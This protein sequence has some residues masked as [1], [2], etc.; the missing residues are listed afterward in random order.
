MKVANDRVE[1]RVGDCRDLLRAMPDE[2]VDCV[3]TSP[4]YFALRDYGVE[5]QIGL[6]ETP[7]AFVEELVSVFEEV[8]RVLRS[9]GT[10]WI[11]LGDSY[12]G[13]GRGGGGSFMAE[14]GDASW[15]GKGAAT[16]WQSPPA[17]FKAKDLM[18]MPWRVAL[19]LQDAGWFLRQDII[20]HKP[21]PMP[22]SVAD[23]CTK[24]HEY[25]FLLSKARR[26]HY[27]A[28]AIREPVTP[29]TVARV[30]QPN[31]GNQ[32]GS[33]RVP[34][35]T[36]GPM[37]AV[38][39]GHEKRRGHERRHEGL[40]YVWDGLTKEE[41]AAMGRNKPS[42]WT[43]ARVTFKSDHTATYPPKL[44]EPCILAG[45]PKGGVVL[46]PFG[47]AGTTGLVAARHGR[48]AI[49]LELNPEYAAIARDRIAAEWKEPIAGEPQDFGPLFS[50]ATG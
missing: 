31:W 9:D 29:S 43:V 13:G 10:C 42:V 26:Y 46:D 2:S 41:Q 33:D 47:G 11:N 16:G 45:C 6:E 20:W 15:S 21:N 35:K 3:V 36:N 23:R 12:A 49:L 18:G 19:A 50:E 27:D 32:A 1:I 24:A 17:G 30:S 5:G 38:V 40:T 48:R 14:R 25:I 37:K 4:P 7:A 39:R 22:E 28:E 44:I 8:R 34:G